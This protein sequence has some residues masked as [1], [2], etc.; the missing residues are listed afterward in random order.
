MNRPEHI[1]L[2]E[3]IAFQK[4]DR[5][6]LTVL[7]DGTLLGANKQPVGHYSQGNMRLGVYVSEQATYRNVLVHRVVWYAKN[8]IPPADHMVTFKD[9]N[10]LNTRPD[11]LILKPVVRTPPLTPEQVT[12]A[13]WWYQRKLGTKAIAQ[14]LGTSRWRV[15]QVIKD[16]RRTNEKTAAR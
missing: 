1:S 9:G 7:D 14:K 15:E 13:R 3:W 12:A 2:Q 8:G 4:V 5:G 6:L 11:N 10:A 16:I